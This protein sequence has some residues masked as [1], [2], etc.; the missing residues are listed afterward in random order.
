MHRVAGFNGGRG[1]V[2]HC[3]GGFVKSLREDSKVTI[4][5]G[6]RNR[7]GRFLEVAVYAMG[8]QRGMTMFL[9]GRDRQGWRRDSRELSKAPTFL[10][11]T[12]KTPFAGRAPVDD[13]LGKAAGPLSFAEV[14]R[15]KPTFPFT[16]SGLLV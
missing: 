1:V 7:C 8:S 14:V 10:E 16:W 11:A 6:G 15:L 3:F 2:Q 4:V 5:R 12:V 9:E 13:C